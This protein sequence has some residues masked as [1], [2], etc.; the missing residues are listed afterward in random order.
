VREQQGDL[1]LSERRRLEVARAL[2][3]EPEIVL[4]DEARWR[5]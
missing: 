1:T 3:L 4:L 2:A 5:A